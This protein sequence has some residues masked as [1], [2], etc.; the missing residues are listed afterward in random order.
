MSEKLAIVLAAG[1]GTRIK[2]DLPKVLVHARG[3]PMIEYVLAA[4][5]GG[6][7][8]RTI[9]VVGYRAGDVRA[10]L[11]GRQQIVF[12]HQAEQLGTGHAVMA[13]RD[14]LAG[15]DGPVLVVAGDAP[16]MQSESI[17]AM[18]DKYDRR[19]VACILGTVHK[20]DPTGLGR[21]IRDAQGDFVAIVEEKEATDQ[22]RR[23]TEVNMSYY[24]FRC[25]DLLEALDRIRADN[26]QKEYYLTDC[27]GV[28]K[29]AGKEVLA[30][31]VLKPCEALAV[32]NLEE[33]AAVEAVMAEKALEA[34]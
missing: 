22:Q 4:V 2:S 7:V 31:D 20:Q 17:R 1:K 6:G 3:R 8:E 16:L 21:I 9:V 30:L 23:V 29:A 12:A 28:L 14:Y 32:N 11:E 34:A 18:L 26:S 15:H 13:C 10:A 27:P 33:L 19:P 25:R 24:V 5:V